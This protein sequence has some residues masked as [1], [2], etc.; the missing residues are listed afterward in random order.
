MALLAAKGIFGFEARNNQNNGTHVT[1]FVD[2]ADSARAFTLTSPTAI[3]KP[4]PSTAFAGAPVCTI[5]GSALGTYNRPLSEYRALHDGTGV[6]LHQL[7]MTTSGSLQV[8]LCTQLPSGAGYASVFSTG[9]AYAGAY[10]SGG[11]NAITGGGGIANGAAVGVA[12]SLRFRYASP[13]F[14]HHSSANVAGDVVGTE[15][16]SPSAVDGAPLQLF[17]NAAGNAFYGEWFGT[18]AFEPLTAAERALVDEYTIAMTG[19]IP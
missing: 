8:M 16:A 11:V 14:E 2:M 7:F 4:A 1:A 18:Y 9:T 17:G 15:S 3:A 19:I 5:N 6:E 13:N 10:N 12:L